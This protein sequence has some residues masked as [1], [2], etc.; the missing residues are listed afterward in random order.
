L[1]PAIG[2]TSALTWTDATV[3]EGVRYTYG[4]KAFDA[5]GNASPASALKS[6]IAFQQPTRPGNF[7]VTLANG[8]PR[9]SWTASTDNVGVVGYNIYRSTNGTLGPLFAQT[10]ASP[11]V[12]TSAA[13]GVKYTYA[14]RARDAAGYLSPP[15]PHGT[16]TAQ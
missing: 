7:S 14:V 4:V 8:H 15:T 5:A 12:D 6:L 13:A 16:I 11:W 3:Q 2:R 9:L 10:P 1:G